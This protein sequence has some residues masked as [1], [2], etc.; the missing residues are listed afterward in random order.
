MSPYFTLHVG[1]RTRRGPGSRERTEL[2]RDVSSQNLLHVE[3][4]YARDGRSTTPPRL[5]LRHTS[6]R[7]HASGGMPPVVDDPGILHR[8]ELAR[9]Y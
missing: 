9:S 5:S 6:D 4:L 8:P 2:M 7:R 3:G 1:K